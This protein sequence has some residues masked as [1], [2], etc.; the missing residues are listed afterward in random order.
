[1]RRKKMNNLNLNEIETRNLILAMIEKFDKKFDRMIEKMD[2]RFDEM[3]KMIEK[4]DKKFDEM[5]E[6]MDRRFDEMMEKMDRRF[7][8]MME[9]MDKMMEKF[10][11]RFES[12][13]SEI[14][15]LRLRQNYI[16]RTNNSYL[17]KPLD[18][19]SLDTFLSNEIEE[20]SYFKLFR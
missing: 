14:K 8:E 10:D 17:Q 20:N 7:D 11:K 5:M 4:F 9:K 2:K 13:E 12:L 6:K 1:M 3:D 15:N 16:N 19:V 18:S